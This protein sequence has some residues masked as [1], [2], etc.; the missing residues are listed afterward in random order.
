[1]VTLF[2]YY[3]TATP[4][5]DEG[6]GTVKLKDCN[7]KTLAT[8]SESYAK[9]IHMEGA[10]LLPNGQ[11]LNLNDAN[12]GEYG[13]YDKVTAPTR[14]SGKQLKLFSSVASNTLKQGTIVHVAELEGVDLPGGDTHNGC[15][16]VDDSRWREGDDAWLDWYVGSE[17]NYKALD[18]VINKSKVTATISD[19]ESCPILSYK[20]NLKAAKSTTKLDTE[21]TTDENDPTSD[22]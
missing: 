21:T 20:S 7:G 4:A 14:T 17:S 1:M 5:D 15:V 16:K 8:V 6:D 9:V 22:E 12:E 2:T 19:K 13:C 11:W 18:K 3:W 10:G